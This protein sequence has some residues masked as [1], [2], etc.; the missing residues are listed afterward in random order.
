MRPTE[1]GVQHNV[2]LGGAQSRF[3]ANNAGPL[4]DIFVFQSDDQEL[5]PCRGAVFVHRGN[6][7]LANI[8]P[9]L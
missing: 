6:F 4:Q 3:S 7:P 5:T 9:F 1:Y 2:D 8:S